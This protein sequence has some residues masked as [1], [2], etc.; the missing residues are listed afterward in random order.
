MPAK[1]F[2]FSLLV[3]I[4]IT[5]SG[6]AGFNF[7][8]DP[9]GIFGTP[10]IEGINRHKPLWFFSQGVSKPY[11]VLRLRPDALVLGT[12]RAGAS[13]RTDHPVWSNYRILN[14]AMPGSSLSLQWWNLQYANSVNALRRVALGLDLFMFNGCEKPVLAS[15]T[16]EYRQRLRTVDGVYNWS[17]PYRA[18]QDYANA[19]I[20]FDMTRKSW[21]TLRLQS[22]YSRNNPDL[23]RVDGR[24]FWH[25]GL[26]DGVSQRRVFRLIEK[27]YIGSDWALWHCYAVS[28]NPQLEYF[29]RILRYSHVNKIELHMYFSPFHARL[30]EAMTVSGLWE[31]FEQLKLELVERNEQVALEMGAKPFPLWDFSGYT[32][33]NSETVPAQGDST[34]RMLAYLDGTH[35]TPA[36]GDKILDTLFS[37]LNGGAQ[38]DFGVPLALS[39]MEEHLAEQRRLRAVWQDLNQMEV[40][41]V[42]AVAK[43]SGRPGL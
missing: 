4:T 9:I 40:E 2:F 18:L 34:S 32:R 16:N 24:G 42:L 21:S 33:V 13:L 7:I 14:L 5:L 1:T 11:S 29:D 39:H 28:N 22:Q 27:Q 37:Q 17:F 8:I 26:R 23:L 20:S 38:G 12:S 3:L 35:A 15:F 41:D 30:A 19:L 6:L 36:T 43:K 31:V 25:R 10:A